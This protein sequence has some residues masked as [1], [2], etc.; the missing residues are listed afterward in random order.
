LFIGEGIIKELEMHKVAIRDIREREPDYHKSTL[1]ILDNGISKLEL[2]DID[3]DINEPKNI[4]LKD[5]TELKIDFQPKVRDVD[6]ICTEVIRDPNDYLNPFSK[7]RLQPVR[8]V[9][10]G[11]AQL[12]IYVPKRMNFNIIK[13][14]A[15]DKARGKN[16][17]ASGQWL[18]LYREEDKYNIVYYDINGEPLE[19]GSELKSDQEVFVGK[20]KNR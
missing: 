9:K 12:N 2:T 7:K 18:K 14:M 8:R 5:I 11:C 3:I 1:I 6:S 15:K 17:D 4:S 10:K 13:E 16:M 20:K 19:E